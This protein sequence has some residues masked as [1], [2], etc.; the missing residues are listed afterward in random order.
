VPLPIHVYPAPVR[1][2]RASEGFALFEAIPWPPSARRAGGSLHVQAQGLE[3]V[4]QVDQSE[5]AHRQSDADNRSRQAADGE[6][7]S[8]AHLRMLRRHPRVVCVSPVAHGGSS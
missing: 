7:R 3:Q 4:D 8:D 1:G 2:N 6:E 5:H